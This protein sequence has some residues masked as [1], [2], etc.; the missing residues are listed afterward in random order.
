MRAGAPVLET[1]ADPDVWF[2]GPD[3]TRGFDEWLPQAVELVTHTVPGADDPDRLPY[4]ALV[5]ARIARPAEGVLPH[6]MIRWLDLDELPL[7]ATFAMAP[8]EDVGDG[9]WFLDARDGE[10]VEPPIVDAVPAPDGVDVRRAVVWS[11]VDGG[12]LVETRYVVD[13]GDPDVVVL[14]QAAHRVPGR[15]VAVLDDLDRL[16][17]GLR[18][19]RRG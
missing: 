13:Q 6:R 16:A 8:R 15:V 9:A 10:P 7:V 11:D 17:A 14:V 12:L 1:A 5:L 18:V 4:I 2:V 3:A 19:R